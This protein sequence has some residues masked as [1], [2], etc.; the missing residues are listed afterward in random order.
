MTDPRLESALHQLTDAARR[1]GQWQA[2]PTPLTPEAV[3]RAER[4]LARA[5]AAEAN[6][7]KVIRRLFAD[8]VA[9]PEVPVEALVR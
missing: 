6:A 8:R 3:R 7:R 4:A 9:L 2:S 1:I 5:E